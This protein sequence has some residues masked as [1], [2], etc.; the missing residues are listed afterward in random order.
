MTKFDEEFEK[1]VIKAERPMEFLY[2]AFKKRLAEERRNRPRMPINPSG[3]LP[4]VFEDDI[5]G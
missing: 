3:P 2:Q 5:N 4:T 1:K